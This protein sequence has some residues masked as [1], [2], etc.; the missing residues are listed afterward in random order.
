ME[1]KLIG[2]LT[3]TRKRYSRIYENE[4]VEFINGYCN[5]FEAFYYLCHG[6]FIWRCPNA[7]IIRFDYEP[8]TGTKINWEKIYNDNKMKF[9]DY[10]EE[11]ER[12]FENP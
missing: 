4:I 7:D 8:Y 9:S 2:V 3:D 1:D 5:P 12:E 6:K 11:K 10:S